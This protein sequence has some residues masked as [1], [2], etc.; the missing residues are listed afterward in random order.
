MLK[1][2]NSK[3]VTGG[4]LSLLVVIGVACRL[5]SATPA[6]WAGTPSAESS[7]TV[8]TAFTQ[9]QSADTSEDDLSTPTETLSVVEVTPTSQPSVPSE[10]PWLVYPAPDGRGLHAYDFDSGKILEI[11]LPEPITTADLNAG[12]SPDRNTLV[13]RAGSPLNTDELALYQ[14][15][16]PSTEVT[17]ITPLLSLS[18]QRE[19]VNQDNDRASEIL[20]AV[21]RPDGL[22]WSPDGTFLAFTAALD[23]NSSDLYVLEPEK[24]RISRLN[25]LYSQSATPF[26]AP[27]SNWLICQQLNYREETGWRSEV[28]SEIS[29]PGYVNHNALYLP[30]SG[31][32]GEVFLGWIN[33]QSF[34]SYSS[35]VDGSSLLREVNVETLEVGVIFQG[36]FVEAAFDPESKSL[37]Y[38]LGAGDI[39]F[40]GEMEGVYLLRSGSASPELLRAGTWHGL[41]SGH[42]GAFIAMGSQGAFA[43]ASEIMNVMLQ[44]EADLQISPNGSWIIAWGDGEH[45]PAG[46]R[47]YQNPGGNLLQQLTEKPVKSVYWAPDS[48]AF[49][50]Q[51]EGAL[52]H[53]SFPDLNLIEVEAGFLEDKQLDFAWME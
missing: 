32:Q 44:D 39:A 16:L 6:S 26:W 10:G 34:I 2:R 45:T 15:D 46:A 11:P 28:V 12:L 51:A 36:S 18:L 23:G 29:M 50:I 33:S 47:L 43:F 37:A 20:W 4:L 31:S 42:G 13:I 49:F 27:E 52:Y 40:G 41:R 5:T 8:A 48:K 30:V 53:L 22:A 9:T 19:L 21:T 14:I 25:G 7:S 3:F 35:S 17:K 1:K 24:D 38:I